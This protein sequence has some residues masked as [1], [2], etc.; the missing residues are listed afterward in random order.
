MRRLLAGTRTRLTLVFA[1]VLAV[2]IIVADSALYLALS[3][4]ETSAAAEASSAG[5]RD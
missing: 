5:G 4:A 2:A 1:A 3:R